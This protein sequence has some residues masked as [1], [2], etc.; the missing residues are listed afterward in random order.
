MN[1]TWVQS[2]GGPLILIEKDISK[3]WGG[4]SFSN[5]SDFET[6]YHKA[7]SIDGYIECIEFRNRDILIFWDEPTPIYFYRLENQ[8]DV[9]IVRCIYLA[10]N[11]VRAHLRALNQNIFKT[12]NSNDFPRIECFNITF[13]QL[14]I[15]DAALSG[16][17]EHC[18]NDEE[19]EDDESDYKL[20]N[21]FELD[22]I[23]VSLETGSYK[24]LSAFYEPDIQTRLLLHKLQ[25]IS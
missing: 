13:N 24:I 6:D 14:E 11:D 3:Y 2:C 17:E 19:N 8:M 9:I 4:V 20:Q 12:H 1:I 16:I 23:E 22:S 21:E 25:R 18:H 5:F 15:R 10:D 7:S